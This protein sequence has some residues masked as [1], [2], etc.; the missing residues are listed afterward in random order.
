MTVADL[1]RCID[2]QFGLA[3][4]PKTLYRLTRSTAIRRADLEVAGAAAAVLDVPL[5]ALFEVRAI[6]AGPEPAANSHRDT[7]DVGRSAR[8]AALF[9]QQASGAL[10]EDERLELQRL[11]EEW[12]Q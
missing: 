10:S 4:D 1:R 7:S 12:G 9:A 2:A 8:L 11:L 3:V 6:R 5:S